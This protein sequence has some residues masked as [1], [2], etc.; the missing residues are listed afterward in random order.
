MFMFWK[1]YFE[2][3]N[4]SICPRLDGQE[5]VGKVLQRFPSQDRKDVNFPD[6][7]EMVI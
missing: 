7:I 4:Q 3:K 6:G 5:L 1:F 2:L